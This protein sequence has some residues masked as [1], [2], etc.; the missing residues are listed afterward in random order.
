[1][2]N[3]Q[4]DLRQEPSAPQHVWADG[5]RPPARIAEVIVSVLLGIVSAFVLVGLHRNSVEISGT[6]VPWG[7]IFGAAYQLVASVFLAAWSGRKLPLALLSAVFAVLAAMFA[8]PSAGGGI[9]MPG[10]I[11]GE[12]QWQGWIVQLIGVLVPIAVLA[13]VWVIQIRRIARE[14][15]R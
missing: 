12:Y 14:H 11:A 5:S 10:E 13:A 8:G 7:L 4:S 15:S 2:T 6:G 3:T 9:L 1:M